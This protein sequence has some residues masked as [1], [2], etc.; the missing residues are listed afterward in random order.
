M[1]QDYGP[2]LG[3]MLVIMVCGSILNYCVKFIAKKYGR[4]IN[5]NPVGKSIFK[6]FKIVFI[7]YHRVFGFISLLLLLSH[8][9]IQF[10]I[11]GLNLTGALAATVLLSQIFLGIY[12][13][14]K[15]KTS[16]DP[17]FIAHR[18]IAI[19]LILAIA[20]HILAPTIFVASSS[21]NEIV[22]DPLEET[23]D[24]K[25]FTVD[26]VAKFNGKDGN[27]GYVIYKGMVYDVTNHPRWTTG[28]HNNNTAG[29]DLT[30]F[31]SKSPHG[32]AKFKELEI[33]G[34]I[35]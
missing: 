3:W 8:F 20:L 4:K 30:D 2:L 35:K 19:L 13:Y 29:T 33:V 28:E 27:K 11:Y 26:E 14:V 25:T 24:M 34:K 22:K 18:I 32:D 12:I 5:K 23:M 21:R 6:V 1:Y 16:K 10:S 15:K 9:L 31:I 7:R 17:A